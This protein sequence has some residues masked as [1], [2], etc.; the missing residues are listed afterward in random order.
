MRPAQAWKVLGLKPCS[1]RRAVKRAYAEKLKAIDPDKDV[2]GFLRLREALASAQADAEWRAH[3]E[4]QGES[5][6]EE[7]WS[8][9]AD[10]PVV[11]ADEGLQGLT[12]GTVIDPGPGY[13]PT[14]PRPEEY[15]GADWPE[16]EPQEV[17]P[18]LADRYRLEELLY[19]EHAG[20]VREELIATFDRILADPALEQLDMASRTEDWLASLLVHAIPRSDPLIPR[21]VAFFRWDQ[22]L[23]ATHQRYFVGMLAQRAE[24]LRCIAALED[25]G[26]Q[27][28]RPFMLLREPAP[29][30]LALKDK[31]QHR[32]AVAQ[33][34]ASLRWHN[35]AVEREFDPA[36][37]ALWDQAIGKG[38][39]AEAAQEADGK[40]SW[41][42]FVAI[43][44]LLISVL[45]A[46]LPDTPYTGPSTLSDPPAISLD[47]AFPSAPADGPYPLGVSNPPPA[48]ALAV[49]PAPG[50]P[51]KLP[52][53]IQKCVDEGGK[54]RI[55]ATQYICTFPPPAP[56]PALLPGADPFR[57][58]DRPLAPDDLRP[59][60]SRTDGD[61]A[62][63][64][65]LAA[66]LAKKAR[67]GIEG[68]ASGRTGPTPPSPPEPGE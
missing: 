33:M 23:G 1:D 36:H 68:K 51:E 40:P 9:D 16:P 13:E 28:H 53:N 41:F 65:A 42:I 30:S 62:D 14:P 29:A 18:E 47:Q 19:G 56:R 5:S 35:P 55:T 20:D 45:R 24:D 60:T 58:A 61:A 34:L 54:L 57:P 27:W 21:A 10:L 17:P 12:I 46:A 64:D 49:V 7:E 66:A 48:P 67:E 8:V 11:V 50:Q 43:G 3:R 6:P 44:W 52:A 15:D 26:H 63:P 22:E 37:V 2:K 25:P 39:A 38:Q 32:P 31:L 59:V 4:A